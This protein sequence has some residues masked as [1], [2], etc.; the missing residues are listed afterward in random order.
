[1][2]GQGRYDIATSNYDDGAAT[3]CGGPAIASITEA[4]REARVSLDNG[5]DS[6][7][8]VMCAIGSRAS[9][10]SKT[11]A[12]MVSKRR[13]RDRVEDVP[14]DFEL[15]PKAKGCSLRSGRVPADGSMLAGSALVRVDDREVWA[16]GL[17]EILQIC[18]E[19]A[20][21]KTK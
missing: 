17:T 1:M 11:D 7:A 19:A 2:S 3:M 9:K 6:G 14:Y 5:S 8:H 20:W 13:L 21:R 18:N 15:V 12:K 16:G 10:L 4:V